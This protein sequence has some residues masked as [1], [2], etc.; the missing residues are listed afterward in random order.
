MKKSILI[1]AGAALLALG[2]ASCKTDNGNASAAS[3]AASSQVSEK[4]S[5]TAENSAKAEEKEFVGT[6]VGGAMNSVDLKDDKGETK[7]FGYPEIDPNNK[8]SWSEGDKVKV[9]YVEGE[10][11]NP[12]SV[13][14]VRVVK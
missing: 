7:S 14:S 6:V 1:L 9:T 4:S 11:E 13:L 8:D 3:S 12:D 5:A 2:T 10:G